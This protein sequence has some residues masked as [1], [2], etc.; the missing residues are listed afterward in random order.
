[1]GTALYMLGMT[2][3]LTI[4]HFL[5]PSDENWPPLADTIMS[6]L[7]LFMWILVGVFVWTV[8]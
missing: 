6:L 3:I 7:L 4:L 8:R 1:M 2:S 5:G